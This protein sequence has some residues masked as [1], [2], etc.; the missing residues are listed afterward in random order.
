MLLHFWMQVFGEGDTAVRALSGVVSLA[1]FPALYFAGR[2]LGGRYAGWAAV[3]V[4]ATAPF[5]FR[6]AT[7]TRMYA[8]VMFLVAWGYLAVVRA[9]ERPSLGRCALVTLLV[10]TLLYT[11]NWSYYLLATLG[12]VLLLR[13]WKGETADDRRSAWRVIAAHGRGW[14]LLRAVAAGRQV[15]ARAHRH[16]VG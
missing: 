4:F 11:H 12:I 16:S 3:L 15:P 5:T 13:A 8:L 1:T 14:P 2:R 7:E 9:L 6:Y 10:A